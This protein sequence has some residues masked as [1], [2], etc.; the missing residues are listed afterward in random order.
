[1]KY[2]PEV[3][4]IVAICSFAY[5]NKNGGTEV[6]G[7]I[8]TKNTFPKPIFALITKAWEDEEIGWRYH[9]QP[10][11]KELVEFLKEKEAPEGKVYFGEF[12]VD[13]SVDP[14][15]NI[16]SEPNP[17]DPTFTFKVTQTD[18]YEIELSIQA[19]SFETALQRLKADLNSSPIDKRKDTFSSSDTALQT[20]DNGKWIEVEEG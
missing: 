18:V 10:L 7:Y 20:K 1:M 13:F 14:P 9:S 8:K 16:T 3:A 6:I 15:E 17:C 12:D 2:I 4:D 11:S 5:T 19:N